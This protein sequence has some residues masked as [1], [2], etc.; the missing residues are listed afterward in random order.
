MSNQPKIRPEW[1]PG[2]YLDENAVKDVRHKPAAK[3]TAT[4]NGFIRAVKKSL[5]GKKS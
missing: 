4:A 2:A 5:P 1:T 3:A